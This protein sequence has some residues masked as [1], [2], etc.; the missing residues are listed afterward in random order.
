[1]NFDGTRLMRDYARL[2]TLG[3]LGTLTGCHGSLTVNVLGSYFPTWML[4][5]IAG[6]ILAVIAQR[7]LALWGIDGLLPVRALTYLSMALS[8]AFALWLLWLG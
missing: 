8:F 1:M 3:G 6:V 7:L 5:A 4:C 2:S